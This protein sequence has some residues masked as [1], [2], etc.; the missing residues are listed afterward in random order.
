MSLHLG[1]NRFNG[2]EVSPDIYGRWDLEDYEAFTE[3]MSG[4]IPA[5]TGKAEMMTGFKKELDQHTSATKAR[6]VSFE[7]T[8]SDTFCL[9]LGNLYFRVFSTGDTPVFTT[10]AITT[11]FPEAALDEVQVRPLNDQ[12]YLT[13]K[14]YLTQ[15]ITRVND[16]TWTIEDLPQDGPALLSANTDDTKTLT[17]SVTTGSGTLTATGF[18]PFTTDHIGS[19]WELKQWREAQSTTPIDISIT[20]GTSTST[21]IK[22][23]GAFTIQTSGF[24]WGTVEVEQSTTGLFA[25]EQVVIYSR[26]GKSDDN[27]N[28]SEETD[29]DAYIR[30][31]F[32]SDGDPYGAGAGDPWDSTL[33]PA[34]VIPT[35]VPTTAKLSS[36]RSLTSGIVEVTGFTSTTVVSIDVIDDLE[37]TT[38]EWRWAEG[39]WSDY[40][41]YPACMVVFEERLIFGGTVLAPT[42]MW[43]SETN[44]IGTWS[45]LGVEDTDP[46][47]TAISQDQN[48]ILWMEAGKRILVGTGQNEY[49]ITSSNLEAAITPKNITVKKQG[50]NGSA[51]VP[52]ISL[53]DTILHITRDENTIQSLNFNIQREGYVDNDISR[54]ARHIFGGGIKQWAFQQNPNRIIWMITAEGNLVGLVYNQRDEVVAFFRRELEGSD[55]FESVATVM[56]TTK[57]DQ[58]WVTINRGGIRTIERLADPTRVQGDMAYSDGHVVI[59]ALG[60]TSVTGLPEY[61]WNREVIIWNDGANEDPVTVSGTGTLELKNASEV[62]VIIGFQYEKECILL[63]IETPA[64]DGA[65]RGKRKSINGF[66]LGTIDTL[67]GYVGYKYYDGDW[68]EG[69]SNPQLLFPADGESFDGTELKTSSRTWK[70]ETVDGSYTNIRPFFRGFGA[71]PLNVTFLI[72]QSNPKGP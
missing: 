62:K 29:E 13:H 2:G 63:P 19:F 52:A 50:S 24:W 48:R 56:G 5:V 3:K 32:T 69:T 34:P 12:L 28:E 61:M 25:G 58:L 11:I 36:A 22:V 8:T 51:P 57:F 45:P 59:E 49:A 6:A 54:L 53:G 16:T 41:G 65:S 33:V 31:K 60:G 64:G 27:I 35:Q 68:I 66:T 42:S 37:A 71:A 55:V 26:T 18:A 67:S 7:F 15:V 10:S 17:P 46:M 47:R 40:Q 1:I 9:E 4:F 72:V 20:T 39:A 21:A 43:Y 14:D 38:A 23:D 30:I 70:E 44:N